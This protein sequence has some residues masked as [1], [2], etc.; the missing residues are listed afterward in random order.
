[1]HIRIYQFQRCSVVIFAEVN[2]SDNT[3]LKLKD[4]W[5]SDVISEIMLHEHNK[6][7]L[8]KL[9]K[10]G[11]MLPDVEIINFMQNESLN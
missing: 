5:I 9:L 3:S 2:S 4:N 10:M 6:I 8:T 1:M 11:K 7:I